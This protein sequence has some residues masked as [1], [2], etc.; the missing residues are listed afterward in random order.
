MSSKL[1]IWN[2]DLA[3][4]ATNWA[5]RC[6]FNH[7]PYEQRLNIGEFWLAGENIYVYTD[8]GKDPISPSDWIEYW[9]NEK[10]C[11]SYGKEG[12]TKCAVVPTK[13]SICGHYT[14]VE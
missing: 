3:Q 9:G 4:L 10:Y 6:D 12:S 7:R 13:C 8:K 11:Y 5:K 1:Q 14:Q 2:E